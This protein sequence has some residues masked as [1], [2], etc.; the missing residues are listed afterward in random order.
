MNIE[1]ISIDAVKPGCGNMRISSKRLTGV[2]VLLCLAFG[3]HDI[4]K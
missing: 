3:L 1:K 4:L 2:H